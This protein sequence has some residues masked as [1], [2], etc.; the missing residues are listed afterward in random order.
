MYALVSLQAK[1]NIMPWSPAPCSLNRPCPS[2]T[3]WSMSGDW[4]LSAVS[5]AHVS[6]SKPSDESVKPM[7]RTTRRATSM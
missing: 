6:A 4:A 2:L 3:P 7:S 5:T 1:P